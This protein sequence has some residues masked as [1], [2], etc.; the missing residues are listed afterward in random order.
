MENDDHEETE[1]IEP[2][3]GYALPAVGISEI[4]ILKS[5][6]I[7]LIS[8]GG[9]RLM[10]GNNPVGIDTLAQGI[11]LLALLCFFV[12]STVNWKKPDKKENTNIAS[13]LQNL[14]YPTLFL[15]IGI[16]GTFLGIYAGL[17]GLPDRGLIDT[18]ALQGLIDDLVTSF[19]TSLMGILLTIE[20][21]VFTTKPTKPQKK[22]V[23]IPERISEI[24][25]MS[26]KLDT[27]IDDLSKK[28]VDGLGE[29]LQGLTT[30]LENVLSDQ[31]G[32]R[33]GL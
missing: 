30:Q 7:F 11:I 5:T 31:L 10:S 9:I 18:S 6:M 25:I 29:A 17:S 33:L 1:S 12:C 16:F 26:E 22:E 21:R 23:G 2:Q 8:W 28:V 14:Q 15:S 19:T 27:F 3:E 24:Q 32:R 20:Y 13:R 4:S